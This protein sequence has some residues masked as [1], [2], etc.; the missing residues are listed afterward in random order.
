M[1]QV[2]DSA[3][4]AGAG[5]N[6][7]RW[8]LAI[9]LGLSLGRSATY[10]LVNLLNRLTWTTPLGEQTT[11]IHEPASPRPWWDLL[12]QLLSIGF[13]LVP[14]ALALFLLAD[15]RGMWTACRGIGLDGSRV[16]RDLAWGAGIAAGIGIPGLAFYAAGRAMGITIHVETSGLSQY[17]WTIPVLVLSAVESGLLEEVIVVAYLSRRLDELAL[18]PWAV[19]AA[20]AVLRGSYHLY[21]GFGP[22]LGNAVMG[23]VFLWWYR[24][25]GRVAPLVAAHA[26]LDIVSF[27][28]PALIPTGWLG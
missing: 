13:S 5:K 15:G 12:Y 19:Y 27:V 2:H 8:E 17:W 4:L 7:L 11:T 9:V 24:R 21:Q 6:R 20:S 22:F 3:P 16:G 1:S 28:G 25:T 14:V 18:K 26:L 23:V 10:A